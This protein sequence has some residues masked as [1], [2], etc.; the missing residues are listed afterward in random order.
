[1]TNPPAKAVLITGAS[2]GIGRA[3]ALL[4]A[5]HGWSVGINYAHDAAAAEATADAVRAAGAQA[6]IVRGDVA[7]ETDVIAM[8]DAVQSAFGRLDALVNNAGIVAP[9]LPLADMDV[10]RLKRVLDTNVLGAYLCAR[11][12]ARRLSTDRGGMGGAIVNVSSIAARLGSPNEYVDYAGS[13]GAVDTLTL[14]LAKELGPRGVRVNAVRPGLIATEIH[15]SGGQPGRA[16]RLGAQ[17][18]LGRAGEADEVAEAIVWLLSD[19][20]SYVTGAL[21]DVGGGR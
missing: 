1:M 11:E 3:T 12:A 8:F 20:A 4:A 10:A 5:A 18:P 6:C 19:A 17:T 15:A 13:K 9:S 2:R 14:G 21:L 16:E 7:N